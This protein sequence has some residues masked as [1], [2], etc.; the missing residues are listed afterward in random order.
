MKLVALEVDGSQLGVRDHD[1]LRVAALVEAGVDLEAGARGGRGNQ[2]DDHLVGDQRLAR[3]FFEM[4]LNRRCSILFH[5]EVPGGKWQ[6]EIASPV[7]AAR[8]RQLGPPKSGAV[9][10]GA[11]AVGGDRKRRGLGVALGAEL[12]PPGADRGDREL[13]GVVVDPDRDEA[14]VLAD[15]V[16]AVGDRLAELSVL[17]VVDPRLGRLALWGKLAADRLEVADQPSSWCR[18][19]SPARRRRAPPPRSR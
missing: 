3:Q 8:P 14:G 17:E 18:P 2:V 13:G 1:P 9:A 6:T 10:V 12:I 19:R 11:A 4:K 15:V 16:D 7:S 5:F